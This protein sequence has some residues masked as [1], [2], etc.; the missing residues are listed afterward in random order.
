MVLYWRRY[1][2]VGGCQI[3]KNALQVTGGQEIH[4]F[5]PVMQWLIK[6]RLHLENC[7]LNNQFMPDREMKKIIYLSENDIRVSLLLEGIMLEDNKR[8]EKARKEVKQ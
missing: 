3:M 5:L 6:P 7:I 1:G 4:E 8:K 2:R